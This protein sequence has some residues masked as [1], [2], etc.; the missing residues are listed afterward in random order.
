VDGAVRPA[1]LTQRLGFWRAI[2]AASLT[3]AAA[4]IVALVVV[5]R[6]GPT[7]IPPIVQAPAQPTLAPQAL[8]M[9]RLQEEGGTALFI[10]TLDPATHRLAV[11]PATVTASPVHSHEL[12]V[13]PASGPPRSLGIIYADHALTLTVPADLA[14]GA[15]LAVSAEPV[16]G[17]PTGLPT[18]PVVA[19]GKL[20]H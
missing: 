3:A 8:A 7:L 1:R 6:L 19:T 9:A 18:G 12:W 4:S 17:S 13:I 2:A 15:T 20:A 11:A 14:D 16:G 10:A 5:P